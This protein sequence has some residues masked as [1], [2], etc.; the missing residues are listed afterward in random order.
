MCDIMHIILSIRMKSVSWALKFR[1]CSGNI[2]WD[3]MLDVIPAFFTV[4]IQ[5]AIVKW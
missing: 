3:E 2:I 4:Y 5:N 1:R